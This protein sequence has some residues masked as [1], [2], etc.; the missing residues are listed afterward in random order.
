MRDRWFDQIEAAASPLSLNKEVFAERLTDKGPVLEK[1]TDGQSLKVGDK[2]KIRITLKEEM[3]GTSCGNKDVH[4]E[5]VA[6]KSADAEKM[7]EELS[8]L[9]AEELENKSK[10]VLPRLEDGR[11]FMWDYQLRG[12]L[13]EMLGIQ[14]ELLDGEIKVGKTKLTKYTPKRIVDN[15]VFVRP[16]KIPLSSPVG[17]DCVRPL[18][19]ETPRG[20]RIA[21]A[22]SETVP[23]G[24]QMEF[25]IIDMTGSKAFADILK[26]CLDFGEFKGLGA[27]RNSGKGTYAYE[28]LCET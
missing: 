20:E 8:H 25:E 6:S 26:K 16:R 7:E 10:T 2:I 5:F 22:T 19:A 12:M 21:L 27:W 28:V 24:T 17:E 18:R 14:C 3:L 1:Y 13:K 23:A 11:P 4:K 9:S 15:F